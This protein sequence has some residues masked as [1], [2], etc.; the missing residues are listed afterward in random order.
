VV[1]Q[2]RYEAMPLCKLWKNTRVYP[3]RRGS[4]VV[5]TLMRR[6]T[7]LLMRHVH[8]ATTLKSAVVDK[9]ASKQQGQN[10]DTENAIA[11]IATP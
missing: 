4:G 1:R 6:C 5:S 10:V 7:L 11:D 2:G 8:N 3:V 9:Q